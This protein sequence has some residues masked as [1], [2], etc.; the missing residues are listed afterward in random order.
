[1][2]IGSWTKEAEH[3]PAVNRPAPRAVMIDQPPSVAMSKWAGAAGIAFAVL[4]L[5][6]F[7]ARNSPKYDAS[8]QGGCPGS[9]I[10]PPGLPGHR[11]VLD[12]GGARCSPCTSWS[13]SAEP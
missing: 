13:L 10:G 9:T 2:S 5:V 1:M 3:R 6:G 11:H 12:G 4:F 8:N 7:G